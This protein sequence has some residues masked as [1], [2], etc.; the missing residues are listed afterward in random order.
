MSK[1]AKKLIGEAVTDEQ[2]LQVFNAKLPQMKELFLREGTRRLGVGTEEQWP[3]MVEKLRHHFL[4]DPD[5]R[6]SIEAH[7]VDDELPNAEVE[8]TRNAHRHGYAGGQDH[9]DIPESVGSLIA[10]K[11]TGSVVTEDQKKAL[12][13]QHESQMKE[14]FI[15]Q[16]TGGYESKGVKHEPVSAEEAEKQWPS[17]RESLE[18]YWMQDR[19]F[20]SELE[21]LVESSRS[22]SVKVPVAVKP[23]SLVEQMIGS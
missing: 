14:A 19:E 17:M 11:L 12:F 13:A 22:S 21:G 5:V 8:A 18:T 16:M 15:K 7:M 10:R 9:G 1:I 2:V 3:A 6:E 23:K 20:E 4:T